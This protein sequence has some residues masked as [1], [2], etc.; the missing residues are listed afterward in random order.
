MRRFT[1]KTI[2]SGQPGPYQDSFLV[3]HITV[4]SIPSGTTEWVNNRGFNEATV[5]A[6]AKAFWGIKEPND[7][8]YS[9]ATLNL[10]SFKSIEPGWEITARAEYND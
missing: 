2:R 5:K 10:T 4:E 3:G 9:W 7:P 8:G 1:F 6:V